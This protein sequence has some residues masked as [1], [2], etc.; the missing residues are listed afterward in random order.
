MRK[1]LFIASFLMLALSFSVLGQDHE[2]VFI[3]QKYKH[4]TQLMAENMLPDVYELSKLCINSVTFVR[5]VVD[6]DG[7][8]KNVACT[9]D[10]PAVIAKSLK[11]TVL[12]TSGHWSPKEVGGKA[13]ESRPYLLPVVYN[14]NF[15]CPKN[16]ESK[17]MFED[18]I[19]HVLV[20]D[21][22]SVTE[23]MECTVLPPLVQR[24]V[25][26]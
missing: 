1:A 26:K 19:Q 17:S 2:P 9:Q 7:K 23:S 6:A 22:G 15:G 13:V 25:R 16:E 12:A 18:A 11:K 21:D 14:V 8:V 24:Y 4:P 5:F 10:T 20:F 3:H